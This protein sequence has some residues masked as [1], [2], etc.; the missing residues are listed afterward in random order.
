L[1]TISWRTVML[2]VKLYDNT[3]SNIIHPYCG[4][5]FGS[6]RGCQMQRLFANV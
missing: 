2:S 1:D 5:V 4:G 3:F 6:H